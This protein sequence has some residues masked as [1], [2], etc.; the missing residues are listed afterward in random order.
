MG[1]QACTCGTSQLQTGW[2][3]LKTKAA[4]QAVGRPARAASGC[5]RTPV[6]A[7]A[8][9]AGALSKHSLAPAAPRGPAA[10]EGASTSPSRN[11]LVAA[12]ARCAAMPG[13]LQGFPDGQEE[14]LP[15]P[16]GAEPPLPPC[17]L[18]LLQPTAAAVSLSV[19]D[20]GS[21]T[22]GHTAGLGTSPLRMNPMYGTARYR[23]LG[24]AGPLHPRDPPKW[25]CD[26]TTL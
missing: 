3:L 13:A 10:G 11:P 24:N 14:Q 6:P 23:C 7:A 20:L 9:S 25:P 5:R 12:P 16:Q 8:V 19:Q 2:L 15:R 1:S 26:Q 4:P 17:A 21:L 18:V 22:P